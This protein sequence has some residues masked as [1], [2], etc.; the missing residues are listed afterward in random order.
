MNSCREVIERAK[1]WLLGIVPGDQLQV[2]EITDG[3]AVLQ[4]L[5]LEFP[6]ARRRRP[7]TDVDVTADYTVGEDGASG[8]QRRV[9]S[10]Y[11]L[12]EHGSRLH[13][14]EGVFRRR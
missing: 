3:L 1:R 4:D 2:D 8:V 6:G 7:W 14:S 9:R 11:H 10:R 13:G 5:V 12:S